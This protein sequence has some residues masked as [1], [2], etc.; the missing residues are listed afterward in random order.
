MHRH[1]VV[2]TDSESEGEE[3]DEPELVEA[4]LDGRVYRLRPL[5]EAYEFAVR[6]VQLGGD[7]LAAASMWHVRL[8]SLSRVL[9]E[10][11]ISPRWSPAFVNVLKRARALR[12]RTHVEFSLHGQL[13]TDGR[14]LA[15]GAKE[16]SS[17]DTLELIADDGGVNACTLASLSN[18]YDRLDAR[19]LAM[20]GDRCDPYYCGRFTAGPKC[21]DLATAAV[22]A[23]NLVLDTCCDL[24]SHLDEVLHDETIVAQLELDERTP[25]AQIEPL[26]DL[27]DVARRLV[28]RIRAIEDVLRGKPYPIDPELQRT[29]TDVLWD[30]VDNYKPARHA[31]Y[32]SGARARA[33]VLGTAEPPTRRAP[34]PPAPV[35]ALTRARTRASAR[36]EAPIAS[37][38]RRRRA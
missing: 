9:F 20:S 17:T 27:T 37:R 10:Q 21:L 30:R 5:V 14:C 18:V 29:G 28:T 7:Y 31:L 11:A 13:C 15:C 34:P 3:E 1:A 8:Q 36:N 25:N 12:V 24:R 4:E 22:L 38:T 23:R 2:L 32:F 19:D 6:N 33:L 26:T 35:V 16:Q